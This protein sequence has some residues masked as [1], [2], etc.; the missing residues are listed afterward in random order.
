MV[1]PTGQ[2][3]PLAPALT[4]TPDPIPWS[5]L[6][7]TAWAL[8]AT[9]LLLNTFRSLIATRRLTRGP[10]VA[11]VEPWAQDVLHDL[12]K[13]L[14]IR[15]TVRLLTS[16]A[17]HTPCVLGALFPVIVLPP[18][19]AAGLTTEQ[20]RVV[21]AH[22]LAHI[23]RHDYLVNLF[24]RLVEAL[25]FFNPPV[26]WISRQLRLERE[27]ACD[28]IAARA[29]DDDRVHV[30]RTLVDVLQQLTPTSSPNPSR[31]TAMAFGQPDQD[32]PVT[33]RIKRLLNPHLPDAVRLPWPTLLLAL[34]LTSVTLYGVACGTEATA[35]AIDKI[36]NPEKYIADTRDVFTAQNLLPEPR[37]DAQGEVVPEDQI[38]IS[39]VIIAHDNIPL[40]LKRVRISASSNS[41]RHG[42]SSSISAESDPDDS[43]RLT[44]ATQL[45]PGAINLLVQVPGFAP[46]SAG[47]YAIGPG[48]R[49]DDVILT[50][51]PGFDLPLQISDVDGAPVAGVELEDFMIRKS[52]SGSSGFATPDLIT[53]ADGHAVL[54]HVGPQQLNLRLVTPGYQRV[55]S[56]ITPTPGDVWNLTLHPAVPLDG[57]VL[58]DVTGTPI[59]DAEIR[60]AWG[61]DGSYERDPRH[62]YRKRRPFDAA[63]NAEGRFTLDTLTAGAEYALFVTA[64]GYAP[65][66][67]PG[68]FAPAAG[69][70]SIPPVVRLRP[71]FELTLQVFGTPE[72]LAA[73]PH[74]RRNEVKAAC[75][76]STEIRRDSNST[77][78]DRVVLDTTTSPATAVFRTDLVDGPATV[79]LGS[80]RIDLPDLRAAAE[81]GP[82][83]VDLTTDDPAAPPTRPVIVR[84]TAPDGWPAPE[85]SASVSYRQNPVDQY[86][87]NADLPIVNGAI[88]FDVIL[89]DSATFEVEGINAP[90]YWLPRP[91]DYQERLT[92]VTPGDIP[93]ELTLALQPAGLVTGTV[94]DESG[95]PLPNARLSL[96]ILDQ[97]SAGRIDS[98]LL[99]NI[100]AD[101]QGRFVISP[102]PFDGRYRV[103]ASSSDVGKFASGH[104]A[105]FTLRPDAPRPDRHVVVRR[106]TDVTVTVNG[107]DGKPVAGASVDVKRQGP[108]GGH[109]WSPPEVT[110]GRG[111]V[112]LPGV[113][114]SDP[115]ITWH[116]SV[117]PKGELRGTRVAIDGPAITVSLQPGVTVTG[118]LINDATDQPLPHA[119]LKAVIPWQA[120][121]DASYDED[122]LATTDADGRFVFTGLAPNVSYTI[123]AKSPSEFAAT[124]ALVTNPGGKV[125]FRADLAPQVIPKADAPTPPLFIRVTLNPFNH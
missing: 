5:A 117:A 96:S 26:W 3:Q 86:R 69:A 53:D 92:K 20:L 71:S 106:G 12:Q 19:L 60:I 119:R 49:K 36:V 93:L 6:A 55:F 16:V 73:L 83:R 66:F 72:Q 1:G 87:S 37:R 40:S 74:N 64:P 100:D 21:L 28:A 103:N 2:T 120:R 39:G 50:L 97:P 68:V 22:E 77:S 75:Q 67:I 57:T 109:S 76:Q 80:H 8:V 82:L 110:D 104:T 124:A 70:E 61:S 25:L 118:T 59:A 56:S 18:A 102:V 85:G 32:L 4:L 33:T 48:E 79:T 111:R 125:G 34:A 30:A 91:S 94:T 121:K 11:P 89:D 35:V 105:P 38:Q 123:Q 63:T 115:A 17:A 46:V 108:D 52:S 51:Q 23:K 10:G 43:T 107:P 41:R 31:T 14:R 114:L 54:S 7:L 112:V 58:S 42:Y 62:P 65:R 98:S 47:P 15:R 81:T 88:S 29:L 116:I 78:S 113:R 84:F 101:A 45:P 44:F 24:Q 13:R 9:L 95:K 99:N 27:A 90:G 122:I